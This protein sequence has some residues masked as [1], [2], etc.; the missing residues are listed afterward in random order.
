MELLYINY[1][2]LLQLCI[3]FTGP[4]HMIHDLVK[5]DI[6]DLGQD[7]VPIQGIG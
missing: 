5:G 6:A 4:V 3:S 1:N 7:Q 2:S